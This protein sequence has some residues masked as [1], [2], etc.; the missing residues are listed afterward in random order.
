MPI[1]HLGTSNIGSKSNLF[2]QRIGIWVFFFLVVV[3]FFHTQK[4]LNELANLYNSTRTSSK[5]DLLVFVK[6]IGKISYSKGLIYTIILDYITFLWGFKQR[7]LICHG[8]KH[9]VTGLLDFNSNNKIQWVWSNIKRS[10]KFFINDGWKHPWIPLLWPNLYV[11]E[12]QLVS[13]LDNSKTQEGKCHVQYLCYAL[14][15]SY[16]TFMPHW[17]KLLS[18]NSGHMRQVYLY[19]GLR[20]DAIHPSLSQFFFTNFTFLPSLLYFFI[21]FIKL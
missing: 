2:R 6:Y 11:E 1:L 5:T 8:T 15:L 19:Y 9:C 13:D 4:S 3:V 10:Q 18:S 14:A 16:V 7:V 17:R 20:S 12:S 21:F